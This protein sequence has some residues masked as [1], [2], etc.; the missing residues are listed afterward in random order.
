VNDE[1]VIGSL[2]IFKP[3]RD[4]RLTMVRNILY[5][6]LKPIRY[7]DAF[8]SVCISYAD[9]DAPSRR[10]GKGDEFPIER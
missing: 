8:Y 2:N 1:N 10:I 6:R 9:K 5:L 3:N 7:A 4:R